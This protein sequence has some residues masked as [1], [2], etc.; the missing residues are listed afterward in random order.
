MDCK[1]KKRKL[2]KTTR[3][4]SLTT[5]YHLRY[6]DKIV[7]TE[8]RISERNITI[9]DA[10]NTQDKINNPVNNATSSFMAFLSE[11]LNL[12]FFSKYLSLAKI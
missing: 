7:T 9:P 2:Q 10:G 4:S 5:S 1:H 3:C 8:V 11:N 6:Y 12:H